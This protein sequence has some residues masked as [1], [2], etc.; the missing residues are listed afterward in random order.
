MTEPSPAPQSPSGVRPPK[1]GSSV[2]MLVLVGLLAIVVAAWYY[3]YSVAGPRSEEVYNNI[4]AMVDESNAKGVRD[5]GLVRAEDV[6]RVVGFAPTWVEKKPDHM[7]EWY[8]W[9]GKV[10]VLSTW[11]RY[12][13]V[14]YEGDPPHIRSHFKNELPS[15]EAKHGFIESTSATKMTLEDIERAKKAAT[16]MTPGGGGM[17]MGPPGGGGGPPGGGRGR[18]GRGGPPGD[19][20]ASGSGEKSEAP[21]GDDNKPAPLPEESGKPADAKAGDSPAEATPPS[22]KEP[23]AAKEAGAAGESNPPTEK[24]AEPPK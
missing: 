11:K 18:G 22:Q 24:L 5:G 2:R 15:E 12:I 9:W 4:Q 17:G 14:V 3:D 13:T 1:S 16:A 8:C 10:P 19:A 7:V 6:Q 21:S 20:P 23:A